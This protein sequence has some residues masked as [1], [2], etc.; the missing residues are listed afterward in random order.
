MSGPAA[1]R[2][3]APVVSINHFWF[4]WAAFR[5]ETRIY[6]ADDRL[7]ADTEADADADAEAESAGVD[8]AGDFEIDVYQG[9]EALGGQRVRF[10]ELFAQGRSVV[11]NLWAGACPTCRAELPHLQGAYEKYG[12]RVIIVA[13]TLGAALFRQAMGRWMRLV[14]PYVHRVSA[15]FV[16]GD[17]AYL[18]Y[19]W[20]FEAGL[21][22]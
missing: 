18:V 6:R 5:P 2:E 9:A 16:I 20:V 15:M 3:L 12:D 10:S 7:S 14:T 4:S 8:L 13:V 22:I 1:G 17:G 19:Y 21:I 11:L